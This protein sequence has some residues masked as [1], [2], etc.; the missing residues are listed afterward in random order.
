MKL[1]NYNNS[2]KKGEDGIT[3]IKSIVEKELD[4][5][6]RPNH[7]EHDFGIDA[8]LDVIAEFGQ[9]TGKTIAAQ[10]KTGESYFK[11]TR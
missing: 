5:I 4:W 8:Y 10:V 11:E 1:P 6:F 7:K 2:S 9:V 3:I